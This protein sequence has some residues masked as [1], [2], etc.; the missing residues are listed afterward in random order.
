MRV[1]HP[2]VRIEDDA[3]GIGQASGS[4]QQD[5]VRA[6]PVHQRADKKYQEPAHAQV[7]DQGKSGKAVGIINFEYQAHQGQTPDD[8]KIN[9][10]ACTSKTYQQK[11]RIG[12]CDQEINADMVKGPEQG[13]DTR[14]R[15]GMIQGRKGVHEQYGAPKY[16]AAQYMDRCAIHNRKHHQQR[17]GNNTEKYTNQVGNAVGKLFLQALFPFPFLC[18]HYLI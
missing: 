10:S 1:A 18:H 13:L 16:A 7:K 17:Y 15:D 8:T 2:F 6:E 4:Q 12:T 14:R 9:P 3:G 11:G 5:G